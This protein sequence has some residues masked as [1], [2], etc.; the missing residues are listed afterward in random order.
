[1]NLLRLVP[2]KGVAMRP[3][4]ACASLLALALAA[5][6]CSTIGETSGSAKT[7]DG[8]QPTQV[9]LVTHESFVLPR[10]L[11]KQFED[12]SGYDLVVRASG[13]AGVLTN[14]LVLTK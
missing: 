13:D 2:A 3:V 9:A 8:A 11:Q 5:T 4:R 7:A 14:K 1:M 10:K 12:E 6:G